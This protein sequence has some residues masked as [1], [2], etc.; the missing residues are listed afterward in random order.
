[1][2]PLTT[3]GTTL[4]L[5]LAAATLSHAATFDDFS[6]LTV[7]PSTSG[8]LTEDG[9]T[10]TFSGDQGYIFSDAANSST[11][12]ILLGSDAHTAR[13]A[14]LTIAFSVPVNQIVF[15]FDAMHLVQNDAVTASAGTWTSFPATLSL[16]G[17]TLTSTADVINP[18]GSGIDDDLIAVLSFNQPT[19]AIR[20]SSSGAFGLDAFTVVPEPATLLLMGIGLTASLS[21]ASRF[22]NRS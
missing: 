12:A 11:N 19:T 10:A 8:S 16:S 15:E 20:L 6:T 5:V 21:R 7:F 14:N 13:L 2:K 17:N 4:S 18:G 1:M 22:T 9:I 3:V